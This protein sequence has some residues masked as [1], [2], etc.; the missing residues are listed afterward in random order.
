MQ[1]QS[2]ELEEAKGLVVNEN[3]AIVAHNMDDLR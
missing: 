2:T 1:N 3:D